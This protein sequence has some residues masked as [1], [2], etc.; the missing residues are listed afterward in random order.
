[1]DA[2][3]DSES[4]QADIYKRIFPVLWKSTSVKGI[5]IWGWIPGLYENGRERAALTW[6]KSY[7]DSADGKV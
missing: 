5:T 3:A 7:L 1:M 6:L 2:S 4:G